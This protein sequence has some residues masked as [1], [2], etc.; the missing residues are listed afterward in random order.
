V[1]DFLA[2]QSD[3]LRRLFFAFFFELFFA[4]FFFFAGMVASFLF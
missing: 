1:P 4:A 2:E 3:Y